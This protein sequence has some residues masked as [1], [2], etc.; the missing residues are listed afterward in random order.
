MINVVDVTQHYGVRPVLR[1]INLRVE[2]G[3]V[4]ALIAPAVVLWLILSAGPT[5][6][7]WHLTGSLRLIRW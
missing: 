6:E 5:L 2:S 3:D 1:Q 4:V 7:E